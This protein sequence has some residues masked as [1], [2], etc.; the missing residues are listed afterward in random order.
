ML[1][2]LFE[3]R[4]YKKCP[5]INYKQSNMTN[6]ALLSIEREH[7][8]NINFQKSLTNVQ[9]LSLEHRNHSAIFHDCDRPI[10]RYKFFF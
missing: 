7:A 9:K 6:L 1:K 2:K 8:N 4:I 10:C 5:F 3:V